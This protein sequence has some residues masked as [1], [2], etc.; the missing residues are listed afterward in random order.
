MAL[1][2]RY[3]DILASHAEDLGVTDVLSHHINTG[4]AQPIHQPPRRVPLPHR[5]KVEELLNDMLQKKVISPS[6]SPWASPV[7]LVK[8]KDGST[9]FC[10][11][12]RKVNEITRKDAYPIPRVDDTLDTPFRLCVV[13]HSRPQEWILAGEGS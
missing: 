4:N 3:S 1:L 9:R 11:D 6:Q 7:V 13:F 10:I 2:A 12:Y 8:K 5:G